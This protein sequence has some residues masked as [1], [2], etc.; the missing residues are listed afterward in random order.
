MNL[1]MPDV[2]TP[3]QRHSNMAAIR[4]KDTKPE[5]I[6]RKYL[7]RK[8]YRYRLNVRRL[9]GSPDIVL[10]RLHTVIL[11]NGCFW[12]GHNVEFQRVARIQGSSNI[13]EASEIENSDCC[14]I[15]KTNRPFWVNKIRRNQE[16]DLKVRG[17]LTL[18]GWNV[19]QIWECQLKPKVREI[20]LASLLMTLCQI[21]LD[22]ARKE[23]P[24]KPY[25]YNN[26]EEPQLV[27]DETNMGK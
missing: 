17:E 1:F 18:Q 14:K 6:V 26:E 11:V 15:P 10:R 3:E 2:Q 22:L 13:L 12:H 4:G 24:V 16:R 8:G 7:H 21:E 19:I 9:P 20:T 27:A 5:I 25:L 23:N